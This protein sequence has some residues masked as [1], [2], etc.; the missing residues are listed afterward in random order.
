MLISGYIFEPVGIFEAKTVP[1]CSSVG[2]Q[3]FP[4]IRQ[5]FAEFFCFAESR[6]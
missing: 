5:I 6:L 1:F 4:G 2:G 3:G